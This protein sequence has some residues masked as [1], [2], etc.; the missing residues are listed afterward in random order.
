MPVT[1]GPILP[2][3]VR[4]RGQRRGIATRHAGVGAVVEPF[5]HRE[6]VDDAAVGRVGGVLRP[7]VAIFLTLVPEHRAERAIA[8]AEV[9][10]PAKDDGPDE[11]FRDVKF[12][13]PVPAKGTGISKYMPFSQVTKVMGKNFYWA[14]TIKVPYLSREEAQLLLDELKKVLA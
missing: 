9:M 2:P 4:G 13:T 10:G 1:A 12:L 3:E 8:A 14:R 11:R 7:V 6:V 5:R